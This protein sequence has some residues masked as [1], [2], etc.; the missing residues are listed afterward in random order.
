MIEFIFSFTFP[1]LLVLAALQSIAGRFGMYISGWRPTIILGCITA[2]I[3]AMPVGSLPLARW[4]ISINANFSLPLTAILFGRVWKNATG[5]G[6]LFARSDLLA[7]WIFGLAAGLLLYPMAMGLGNFDPY[8]FGWGFSLLFVI[9]LVITIVLLFFGNRFGVVLVA[10]ILAY[11]L[12]LLESPNLWDYLCDPFFTITSAI[13]LGNRLLQDR[14][15]K[16]SKSK[17]FLLNK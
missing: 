9:L 5:G 14:F 10:C 8:E 2:F 17:T 16:H 3:V 7:A 11:D 15:G 1:F 12:H 13:A 4:L 6:G